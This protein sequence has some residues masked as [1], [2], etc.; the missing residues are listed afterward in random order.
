MRTL[1]M[2]L[3]SFDDWVFLEPLVGCCDWTKSPMTST[4]LSTSPPTRLEWDWYSSARFF[5]NVDELSLPL[6]I[7]QNNIKCYQHW[8]LKFMLSLAV[9]LTMKALETSLQY[10]RIAS[11]LW[12]DTI[13]NV[14]VPSEQCSLF[15]T[16]EDG[17]STAWE[18]HQYIGEC[19]VWGDT[20]SI[21]EVYHN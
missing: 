5:I 15:S 8:H 14:G 9:L 12:R 17:I 16:V 3:I 7:W 18:Y 1:A 21:V 10:C 13:S 19:S 4:T 11:V 6:L 2:D 20:T